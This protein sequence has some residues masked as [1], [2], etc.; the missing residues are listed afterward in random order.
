MRV[1]AHATAAAAVE[2]PIVDL[3]GMCIGLV[4]LNS[5]YF[6]VRIYEKIYGW[7]AGL[8]SFAPWF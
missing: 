5:F 2:K 3:R 4:L 1:S 8:E 7:R 6:T